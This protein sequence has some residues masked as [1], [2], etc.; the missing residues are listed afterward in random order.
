MYMEAR[1][2]LFFGR[3]GS[4]KGTQAELLIEHLQSKKREVLYIETGRE[5]RKFAEENNLTAKQV[6]AA[7]ETGGLMPAFLPIWLWSERLIRSLS[8]QQDLIIDGAARRSSEAPILDSALKFYNR[9]ECVIIYIDISRAEAE[10]RLSKRS[11]TDD[12]ARGVA[13][14]MSWFDR[15]VLDVIDYFSDKKGYELIRIDGEQSIEA[16][17]QELLTKLNLI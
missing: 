16:I 11:R 10:R 4:G 8:P 12:D 14:R 15:D 7:I 5:F 9:T 17:S 13:E 6:K 2:Y 1:T 3:S